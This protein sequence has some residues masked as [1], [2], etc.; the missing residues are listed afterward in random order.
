MGA[1]SS[2]GLAGLD[3]EA[4]DPTPDV[5]A[6]FFYYKCGCAAAHVVEQPWS[7]NTAQCADLGTSVSALLFCS[8]LYFDHQLG[9][10]S[11]EWSTKRMTMCVSSRPY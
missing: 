8:G 11:V 4:L 2:L 10:C 7:A 9:A 1:N 5:H 6:L 3:L